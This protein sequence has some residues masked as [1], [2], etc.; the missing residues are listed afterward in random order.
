MVS[1][2]SDQIAIAINYPDE[3]PIRRLK[4]TISGVSGEAALE[5]TLEVEARKTVELPIGLHPVFRVPKI[6]G[7]AKISFG[8]SVRA[9]TF[10]IDPV[11]GISSLVPDQSDRKLTEMAAKDG[12]KVDMSRHPLPYKTEELILV[13]GHNGQAIFEN[14]EE[15]YAIILEWEKD[16]YPGCLLWISNLGRDAFPW[17]GKFQAIGVEPV[18]AAFDLGEAHSRN[19]NNPL[20]RNGLK[21]TEKF[22][23]GQKW[24]TRYQISVRDI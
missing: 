4:R 8:G 15:G 2:S 11:K 17:D 19:P 21:C 18:S 1:Q 20:R 12:S 6:A 24:R 10:P 9:N 7:K 5:F 23:A 16:I 3:H 14:R 22:I 13:T